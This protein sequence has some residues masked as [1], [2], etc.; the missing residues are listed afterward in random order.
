[1]EVK[2][3]QNNGF[4]YENLKHVDFKFDSIPLSEYPRPNLKRDSFI[5][6]N[7]YWDLV[8]QE[9]E[10][11]NPV[12]DKKVLVP[13][14]IESPLSG[15]NYLL[16]PDEFI[17]YKRTFNIKKP[18]NP[19]RIILNCDGID[20]ICSIFINNS[21]V[22]KHVGGYTKIRFDITN[23]LNDGDNEIL[24]KVQ[25]LT[26]SSYHSRGKQS[27]NPNHQYIYSSSSGIYKPVW[28][29]EVPENYVKSVKFTPLVDE[30]SVLVEVSTNVGG[31]ATIEILNGNYEIRTNEPVKLKLN[32]IHY[33]DFN[34]PY[35]YI[36]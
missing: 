6:L 8:I 32:E 33:W 13:F 7:G 15:I 25:D 21:L 10:N 3:K 29:E 14:A 5:C 36:I 18:A 4:L 9:S 30:D 2:K 17:F 28:L 34:N 11:N 26:D 16:E 27:L 20:Q 12:F 31:N 35:L 1:M 19:A 23:F 24:I 22:G